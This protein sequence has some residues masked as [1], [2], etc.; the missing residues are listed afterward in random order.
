MSGGV[1]RGDLTQYGLTSTLGDLRKDPMVLY[2][3]FLELTRQLFSADY[4]SDYTWTPDPTTSKVYIQPEY[5]WDDEIVEKRP[6]VFISL[7][8]LN[9][10]SYTQKNSGITGMNLKEAEYCYARRLQG[11]VQWVIIGETKG[12]ALKVGTDILNYIDSFGDVIARDFCFEEFYVTQFRPVNVIKEARERIRTTV[13]ATFVAQETWSLKLES[14]KL[15][16]LHLRAG[17]A[18]ND[19]LGSPVQ[20]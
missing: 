18:I 13:S 2:G 11:S 10:S 12:E 6:A 17:Q 14:P 20:N 16:E 3:I 7:P 19:L 8:E 15:K 1:S 4:Y 9:Y 5:V